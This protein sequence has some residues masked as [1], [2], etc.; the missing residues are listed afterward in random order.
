MTIDMTP[1]QI[2]LQI[3]R[4]TSIRWYLFDLIQNIR[5]GDDERLMVENQFF[6]S[7]PILISG[8]LF[9]IVYFALPTDAKQVL[10]I[11]V[12]AKDMAGNEA[13]L[14]LPH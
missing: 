5:A 11:K 2:Y 10:P 6:K 13:S 1:P 7:Y 8:K 14:A 4:T 9:H 12:V 3:R